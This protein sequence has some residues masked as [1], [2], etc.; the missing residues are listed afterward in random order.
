MKVRVDFADEQHELDL[1][2]ERLIGTWRGPSGLPP[3]QL[4]PEGRGVLENPLGFP[5]FRQLFVPGDRI[6]IALDPTLSGLEPVL[7]VLDEVLRS[8]GIEEGSV[9]VVTTADASPEVEQTLP[10]GMA[11]ARHEPRD[12]KAMAYLATTKEGRRV[13]LNRYLTDADV[14]IPLGRLGYDPITGYRGPWSAVFPALSNQETIDSYRVRIPEDP[15]ERAAPRPHLE[16]AF[17]VSWLL[18]TQF[19]LGAVPGASGVAEVIA[20]L[21]ESVRERGIEA[22]DGRWSFQAPA[23]AECVIAG[24]GRPR[25]G[26][27]IDDLVEGLVT[28]SRL[29]DRGGKIIALSRVEGPIGPSLRRLIDAGDVKEAATAL[30]GHEADADSVAGRRLARVLAWADVYLLSGLDRETVGDLSMV[31][32]DRADEARRLADR[33]SS[34]L[35]VSQADL[36]RATVRLERD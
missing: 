18:G 4:A 13:Y 22:V 10:R 9:T 29:V 25:G 6:A 33:S 28:A 5:P 2:S 19:H 34:V 26:V 11:L 8:A 3:E 32:L 36:T 24:I 20:G 21:A 15:H 31:P 14:V 16:E 27:G 17:E 35:V 7:G 12:A 23:R 1:S 30:R